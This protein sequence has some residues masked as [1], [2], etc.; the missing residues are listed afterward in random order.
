MAELQFD[1]PSSTSSGTLTDAVTSLNTLQGDLTISGAGT[2]FVTAAGDIVTVS[3]ADTGL[4]T[5]G[6]GYTQAFTNQTLVNIEHNFGTSVHATTIVGIDNKVLQAEVVFGDNADAVSF[7]ESQS[8]TVYVIASSASTSST[9]SGTL[10]DAYDLGT[11]AIQ[12]VTGKPVVISGVSGEEDFRVVGSGTFTEALTVGVGTTYLNS[13]T[14]TTSSGTF[15]TS[16]IV[17][18]TSVSLIDPDIS[19]DEVVAISGHLQ[20]QISVGS[21]LSVNTFTGALVID[22]ADGITIED[23]DPTVTI[24]GFYDEFVLASGT[25]QTQINGIDGGSGDISD[26]LVGVDGITITSG[27][28]IARCVGDRM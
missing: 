21:V 20:D 9:L 1:C 3:G 27:S 10:Q 15:I 17:S 23:N 16:L 6:T 13:N 25:L 26:A 28:N 11:G 7:N 14:I 5:V 12:T 18:G 19:N 2:V 8:G 4:G 22:G 24:S